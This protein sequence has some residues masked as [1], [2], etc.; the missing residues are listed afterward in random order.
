QTF[1]QAYTFEQRDV[2]EQPLI[3]TTRKKQKLFDALYNQLNSESKFYRYK[4]IDQN[5]TTMVKDQLIDLW[6]ADLLAIEKI[7]IDELSYRATVNRFLEEKYFQRLGIN[8]LFGSN[9]DQ[10]ANEIFLPE[11]LMASLTIS[12]VAE[13]NIA[14]GSSILYKAPAKETSSSFLNSLFTVI[15]ILAALFIIKKSNIDLLVLKIFGGL[16][17]LLIVV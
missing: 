16:G 14:E 6:S 4:F 13:G 12:K 17:V 10:M 1:I 7:N 8:L 15:I 2:F 11:E 5:C 9:T 3:A